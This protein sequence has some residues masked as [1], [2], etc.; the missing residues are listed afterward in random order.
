MTEQ[1]SGAGPRGGSSSHAVQ[2]AD[3]LD[4]AGRRLE[5]LELLS[6]AAAAGDLAAK[7]MVGLRILTGDGAP[8]LG[9]QGAGLIEDAAKEGDADSAAL[10]AMLAGAGVHRRQSWDEALDWLLRAAQMGHA[11]AQG[12]LRVL[13][14]PEASAE[15]PD[16]WLRLR[17]ACDLDAL[18]AIPAPRT[19]SA[20]PEI[21]TWP[22]FADPALRGWLMARA[23]TRLRR[24]EVYNPLARRDVIDEGRTNTTATFPLA[25]SDLAQVVLQARIARACDLPFANLEALGVLRYEPGQEFGD[26]YD[27]VDPETPNYAQEIA[28]NG[29]RLATFLVYLSDGYDGGE[30]DF[31]DLGVT[32]RGAAG[33][34]L[35]F[36]NA[37]QDGAP[38][39]RMLH[40][41]RPPR[42]GEKWVVSQWLRNR[43]VAPGI[44]PAW[45]P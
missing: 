44:A 9:P 38:D 18:L 34:G 39:T 26:H 41:G 14:A 5:S 10:T 42:S 36:R 20:D 43:P 21:L 22:D 4:G 32:H 12:Q 7:R 28:H 1:D 8:P 25:E 17:A 35:M 15:T 30:T 2:E 29:Q 24:A 19:L 37:L 6:R 16:D 23:Q 3:S 31:P 27:F 45:R 33:E 40:A 13:T 11:G